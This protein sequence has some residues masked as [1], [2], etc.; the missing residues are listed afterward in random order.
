V[1][2]KLDKTKPAV[3]EV[4]RG[5]QIKK[6]GVYPVNST[7]IIDDG[8][9]YAVDQPGVLRG[10]KLD[11]GKRLWWTQKPIT[12]KEDEKEEHRVNTGTAFLVKNGDRY[13]LFSET[14]DLIIAN[15][16]PK[17]YEEVD[18]A[19]L[20]E[21]TNECFGRPVV[22]SHPAFA[23]KCVFARNDKEIVCYSLAAE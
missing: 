20:L 15:L 16:S 21:T 10:V 7:P 12:G 6:N 4:W 8:I 13:F 1:C 22:W 11:T 18:R 17:G 3:E 5:S 9:I 2:L 14:G 19:K 23:N